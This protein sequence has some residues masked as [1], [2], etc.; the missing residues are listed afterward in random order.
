DNGRLVVMSPPS[1]DNAKTEMRLGAML[2]AQG[3]T[4]GFGEVSGGEAPILLWRNPDRLVA[5]DVAFICTNKLPA[6]KS[7]QGYLETIPD[8]VAEIVSKNDSRPYMQRKAEDYL[9]AGVRV[10]WTVDPAKR[11]VTEYRANTETMTYSHSDILRA[12]D[13]ISGLQVPLAELFR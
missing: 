6:R 4:R 7:P 1:Y 9:R 3:E 10:V 2:Y 11:V 8:L 12:E 5:A 13:V